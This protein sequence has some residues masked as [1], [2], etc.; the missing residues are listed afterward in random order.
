MTLYTKEGVLL[1]VQVDHLDGES[2]GDMIDHFYD[3]GA[4]NVQVINTIT[5]KNRP[6]YLILIDVGPDCVEALETL[7]IRECGSGGWHRIN[8]E[9]R[10]TTL[11]AAVKDVTIKTPLGEYE[12]HAEG[13]II[14]EN[15]QEVRPEY[16]SCRKLKELIKEK[17]GRI[18]TIARARQALAEVLR[19]EEGF[20]EL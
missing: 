13:K 20:V 7:I 9:H 12:F 17:E 1:M 19:R 15:L 8:T 6:G 16:E 10:H 3:N 5:K 4:R 11:E 2:I 14:G 18:I